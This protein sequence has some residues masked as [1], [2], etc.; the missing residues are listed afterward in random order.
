[1]RGVVTIMYRLL[2]KFDM[3]MFLEKQAWAFE[4]RSIGKW[5]RRKKKEE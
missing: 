3:D 2:R 4:A 5:G 1:M